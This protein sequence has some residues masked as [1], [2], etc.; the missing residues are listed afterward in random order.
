[1]AKH[2]FDLSLEMD[3]VLARDHFFRCLIKTWVK[4]TSGM[5]KS[6]LDQSD[7]HSK[8]FIIRGLDGL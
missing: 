4:T 6:N 8:E 7:I 3:R 2:W 5:V 1:M